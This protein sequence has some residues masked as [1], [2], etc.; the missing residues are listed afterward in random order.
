MLFSG[1]A[2]YGGYF[3]AMGYSQHI[4]YPANRVRNQIPVKI[5]II[6]IIIII[7]NNNNKHNQTRLGGQGDPLGIVQ[8]F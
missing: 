7:N 3:S 4:L 6:I 2:F 1:Y 5:I 8:E